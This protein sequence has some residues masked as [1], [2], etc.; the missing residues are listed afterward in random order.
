MLN[1]QQMKFVFDFN[2]SLTPYEFS[3]FQELSKHLGKDIPS[4]V[5]ECM[6]EACNSRLDTIKRRQTL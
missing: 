3:L 4:L 5:K 6:L 1:E 2:M